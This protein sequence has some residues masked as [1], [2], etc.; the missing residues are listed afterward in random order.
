MRSLATI[1]KITHLS[2]I[3]GA[4]A[5]EVAQVLGW[6]VVVKKGEFKVG[7]LVVYCE[8]DSMLP[9]GNP[10]FEFLRSKHFRIK[11]V[12]LR[13]QVSQGIC[14][15]TTILPALGNYHHCDY[16]QIGTD[17]TELLGVSQY[18]API[19]ACLQGKVLGQRPEFVPKT[20][21]TRVQVLQDLLD[22][23]RERV[24]YVSEKLDG[25]SFTAYYNK[26]K[27]GICSRKLELDLNDGN[28]FCSYARRIGLEDR[29]RS[30]NLDVVI[31]G[32]LIGP[33]I[34]GN[35][36]ALKECD[37]RFFNVYFIGEAKYADY[38]DFW[39][40]IT[41]GLQLQTVPLLDLSANILGLSIDQI[42]ELARDRSRLNPKI[43]RE[44]VVIR[45]LNEIQDDKYG[46]VSFKAI[47][48]D[49]LLKY[50]DE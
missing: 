37:V 39:L 31:Q 8:V 26:G 34:Q 38:E 1:Q 14:F 23:Y 3:E 11:T 10:A 24:F 49:F 35:K 13:G 4:D 28:A 50:N 45:P 16:T 25:S 2:P 21:E 30:L 48:P 19:P 47:N 36:Y 15:P 44:G 33:G 43:H 12:K 32:E 29:M 18:E 5:I 9:E 41:K 20:D 42:V 46:R 6:K 17:V 27:F 22:K 7:D 40:T